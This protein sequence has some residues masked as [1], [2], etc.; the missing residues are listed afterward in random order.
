MT[1]KTALL[2]K[3]LMSGSH[4]WNLLYREVKSWDARTWFR[5]TITNRGLK[6]GIFKCIF[7][8]NCSFHGSDDRGCFKEGVKTYLMAQ[9]LPHNSPRF[10]FVSS[11]FTCIVYGLKRENS[12]QLTW[13]VVERAEDER[14][15]PSYTVTS[16]LSKRVMSASFS[17]LLACPRTR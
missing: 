12:V 11:V 14:M 16:T 6:N 15:R 17:S 3:S 10:S 1:L 5:L 4:W 8:L 2:L 13:T 7:W 9:I